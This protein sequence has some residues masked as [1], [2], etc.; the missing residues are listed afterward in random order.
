LLAP[1]APALDVVGPPARPVLLVD[2]REHTYALAPI[3]AGEGFPQDVDHA[4][5]HYAE[6]PDGR[7]T[8]VV[9]ASQLS[10]RARE[11]IESLGLG[12]ADEHGRARII[13]PPGLLIS[14]G[15]AKSGTTGD[16]G[17]RWSP[18]AGAVAEYLL[19]MLSPPATTES[20][21]VPP[22]AV[23]AA[24][25]P[26][27]TAQVSKVLQA[28]DQQGWT[29]KSG[30]ERGPGAQRTLADPAGLLGSW[31]SWSTR[32]R[33]PVVRAHA[34]WQ[35]PRRF[36]SDRL[37]P[38]LPPRSWALTGWIAADLRAPL[39]T[40]IPTISCYIDAEPFDYEIDRIVAESELRRVDTGARVFLIRAEPQV[41]TLARQ[42]ELPLVGD[43][44]IYAD[45]LSVGARGEEAANNLRELVIGY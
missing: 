9:V 20:V 19:T 35:D 7:E 27:S 33:L 40:Q 29:Q 8:R 13:A 37:A 38:A 26:V 44:R 2:A 43:P 42:G 14:Q 5:L 32:R 16:A 24:W 3:W 17:M 28:F 36:V 30:A 45:L 41:L 6:R 15:T 12:W 31:A 25:L 21:S 4:L 34:T 11:R 18:S 1:L 22:V 39:V 23:V 10:R